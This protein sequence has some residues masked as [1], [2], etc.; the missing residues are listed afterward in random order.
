[1]SLC[2]I[3]K[4]IDLGDFTKQEIRKYD[5]TESAP[6][7]LASD[8]YEFNNPMIFSIEPAGQTS[9]LPYARFSG[10]P[11]FSHLG[12]HQ[13]TRS[14]PSDF[15][16][17]EPRHHNAPHHPGHIIQ[18]VGSIFRLL[19][20]IHIYFSSQASTRAPFSHQYLAFSDC[21]HVHPLLFMQGR[22]I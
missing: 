22:K 10:Y 20:F 8:S 2:A 13:R 3:C 5:P 6:D 9:K 17:A 15:D 11:S 1:M 16:P 18:P 14:H 7:P 19:T 21:P 4:T 12:L